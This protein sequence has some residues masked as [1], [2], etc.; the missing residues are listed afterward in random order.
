VSVLPRK[1]VAGS[2]GQEKEERERERRDRKRDR[3]RDRQ[4]D[5]EADRLHELIDHLCGECVAAKEC[6]R[7]G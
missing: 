3:E 7:V 4:T 6:G 2:A 5:L 1:S